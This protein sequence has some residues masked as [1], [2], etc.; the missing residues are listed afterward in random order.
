MQVGL[1]AR[2]SANTARHGR[3]QAICLARRS[4]VD[5]QSC[6][7]RVLVAVGHAREGRACMLLPS[8]NSSPDSPWMAGQICAGLMRGLAWPCATAADRH[9]ACLREGQ[10]QA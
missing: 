1:E 8:R 5:T 6:C 7:C 9:C 10:V 3:R 4:D 2:G